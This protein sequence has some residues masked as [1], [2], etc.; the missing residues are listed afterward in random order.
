MHLPFNNGLRR[1]NDIFDLCARKNDKIQALEI[2]WIAVWIWLIY[3]EKIPA[4]TSSR[5]YGGKPYGSRKI[6]R[7]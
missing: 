3:N 1:K 2:K 5:D 6:D 4:D 7:C